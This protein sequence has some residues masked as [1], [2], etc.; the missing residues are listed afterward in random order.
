MASLTQF[1][2]AK[3]QTQ[4]ISKS[5]LKDYSVAV[6][7]TDAELIN[8]YNQL[9]DRSNRKNDA[10]KQEISLKIAKRYQV[11]GYN[12]KALEV[13]NVLRSQNV[14]SRELTD[15]TFLA[16]VS[17]AQNAL[18]QMRSTELRSLNESSY[19]P[20]KQ[21]AETIRF[22]QPMIEKPVE[23]E[24]DSF[25]AKTNKS[26]KS[27]IKSNTQSKKNKSTVSSEKSAKSKAGAKNTA[28][29]KKEQA[30]IKSAPTHSGSSPFASLNK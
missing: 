10:L 22:A 9:C 15:V 3:D 29:V 13:I 5:C 19:I 7:D 16:G 18:N 12:L 28:T 27:S 25:K 17:I 8:F 2:F 11:L 4:E 30:V 6:G 1:S 21:L 26:T 14:T 23:V 24:D 20:A